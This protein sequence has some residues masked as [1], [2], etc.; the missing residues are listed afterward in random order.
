MNSFKPLL[1][2]VSYKQ[3]VAKRPLYFKSFLWN[4]SKNAKQKK[5]KKKRHFWTSFLLAKYL[6]YF[7]IHLLYVKIYID[8]VF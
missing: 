3:L 6:T 4:L 1:Q 8:T 5:K 2:A 7:Q